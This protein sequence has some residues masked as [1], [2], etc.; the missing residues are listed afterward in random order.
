M[1]VGLVGGLVVHFR[2]SLSWMGFTT[3]LV[4]VSVLDFNAYWLQLKQTILGRG[5]YFPQR[6][7]TIVRYEYVDTFVDYKNHRGCHH[8]QLVMQPLLHKN[9]QNRSE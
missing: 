2:G 8:Y 7:A 1:V 4:D 9:H 6:L 3:V 5:G